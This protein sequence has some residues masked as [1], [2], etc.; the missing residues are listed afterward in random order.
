MRL[1]KSRV[2]ALLTGA[3]A[4]PVEINQWVGL[5][6]HWFVA[7]CFLASASAQ[8]P[9]SVIVKV[10]RDGPS[11]SDPSPVCREQVALEFLTELGLGL[12]PRLLAS[13]LDARILVLEDLVP[14]IPLAEILKGDDSSLAKEGLGVFTRTLGTLHRETIG[15]R[16]SYYA[17]ENKMQFRPDWRWS[18]TRGHMAS[19]GVKASDKVEAE[20]TAGLAE[21]RGPGPF[22]AFSNGDSTEFNFLVHGANGRFIDFEGAGYRH[23]LIDARYF[24]VPSPEWITVGD[25]IAD[26]L[27]EAYRSALSER[28]PEASDDRRF[29]FAVAASCLLFAIGCRL[30]ERFPRLDQRRRGDHSRVQTVW[31]LELAAD[32][33]EAHRTLPH[34]QG[35]ARKVASALRR[36]WPDADVDR[37]GFLPYTPRVRE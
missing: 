30:G 21:L 36:V 25:P 9:P 31:T 24:Y 10:L 23:A 5:G 27:E 11:P 4:A 3:F 22:L 28:V 37:G 16:A 29:G 32:V 7:R 19:I 18:E 35:W 33:A 34:L 14:F 20:L 2:E 15:H 26:G 8:V 6:N 12:T 1:E 17:Q 13:D